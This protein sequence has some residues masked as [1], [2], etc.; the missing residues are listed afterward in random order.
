M[1]VAFLAIAIV[2][3][4]FVIVCWRISVAYRQ[5]F[6]EAELVPLK[7]LPDRTVVQSL[8]KRTALLFFPVLTALVMASLTG[9]ALVGPAEKQ[10]PLLALVCVVGLVFLAANAFMLGRAARF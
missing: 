4:S 5:S 10:W 9:L 1:T 7:W 3:L 8:P 2:A 6:S